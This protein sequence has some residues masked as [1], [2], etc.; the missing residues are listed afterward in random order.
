LPWRKTKNPYRIL[1]SEVMLQ[2]TQ[3]ARVL[4]KYPAFLK[5]FPTFS[6]LAPASPAEVIRAWQGMGYNR[7]A[8]H[9]R[10]AAQMVMKQYRGRLPNDV[11]AL[12]KLPGVGRYT[13]NAVACF[14]FGQRV[15]VVDTNIRRVFSRL[16]PGTI[17]PDDV[18]AL[19]EHVLPAGHVYEWNQGLMELGALVCTASHPRCTDCPLRQN[20]PSAFRFDAAPKRNRKRSSAR[21]VP[22]R[23]FRGRIV[24][25]LRSLKPGTSIEFDALEKGISAHA[26]ERNR[27]WFRALVAGLQHDGLLRI[28]RR[29]KRIFLSLP[30]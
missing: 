29:R 21:R 25:I 30:E 11:A 3:V 27:H 8:L 28:N 9:L 4:E 17:K 6:A 2:Q 24:S 22:D 16:F 18:W 12:L 23:I 26:E 19:A 14:A 20:C 7:R 10:S 1:L 15:P 5:K 13:A